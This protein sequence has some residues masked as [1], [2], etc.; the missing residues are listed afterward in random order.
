MIRLRG[1]S[2]TFLVGEEPVHALVDVSEEIAQGEHV[3]IMGPSGSG[4]STLLHVLGCL[5]R[6]DRGSYELLGREVG[7]LDE[8]ELSLVRR[9]TIGFVFQFFHLVP[10]LSA[11]ENIE[12]PMVFAGIERDERRERAEARLR[13]VGLEP[14]AGHRPDQLSGG[15]RQRV[16]LARATVLEPK[17]LL[18]DEPTGNLDAASGRQV[19]HL[20]A[21]MNATGLT[22]VVVTHDPAVARRARRILVLKD[23]R[24]LEHVDGAHVHE[25]VQAL[26]RDENGPA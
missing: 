21:E 12:L 19:L 1:I 13:A 10:R 23:G 11:L 26:S 22:L 2:R 9:H 17:L 14:R 3:A 4:K 16:A 24:V 25:A 20:L 8:A 7:G 15:E 6:P 18:A 5:D